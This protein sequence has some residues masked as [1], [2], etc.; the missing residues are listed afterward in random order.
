MPKIKKIT[1]SLNNAH[2]IFEKIVFYLKMFK[3]RSWK[4][5]PNF[6]TYLKAGQIKR[7]SILYLENAEVCSK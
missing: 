5:S 4:Y 6:Q 7:Q 2:K 3:N 1:F